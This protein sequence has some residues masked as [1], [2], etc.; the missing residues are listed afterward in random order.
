MSVSVINPPGITRFDVVYTG[1]AP[2]TNAQKSALIDKLKDVG[3]RVTTLT[4]SAST[5]GPQAGKTVKLWTFNEPVTVAQLKTAANAMSGPKITF[6]EN[7]T[8][9]TPPP[10]TTP[11]AGATSKSFTVSYRGTTGMTVN[12]RENILYE[13]KKFQSPV[14]TLFESTPMNQ[15]ATTGIIKRIWTF[16]IPLSSATV[17]NAVN[18]MTGTKIELTTDPIIR[19]LVIEDIRSLLKIPQVIPATYGFNSTN[20][21]DMANLIRQ[22]DNYKTRLL[23]I[24]VMLQEELA[25]LRNAQTDYYNDILERI[26]ILRDKYSRFMVTYGE[27]IVNARG[28]IPSEK[29]KSNINPGQFIDKAP[30]WSSD[31]IV[32]S[33][34]PGGT[35]GGRRK[36]ST[37][38]KGGRR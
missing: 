13:L 26:N 5:K 36:R 1:T 33:E 37:R 23:Q 31:A 34:T 6:S 25:R 21:N 2:I 32:F 16:D 17:K 14:S 4:E 11:P 28:N 22:N 12:Q 19:S 7:P 9:A 20:F 35:I 29:D 15:A 38:S 24:V 8:I 30:K 10:G 27:D 18:R 3:S